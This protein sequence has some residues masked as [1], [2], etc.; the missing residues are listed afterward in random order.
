MSPAYPTFQLPRDI[1]RLLIF[2]MILLESASL[3]TLVWR[4][5]L[6]R[7]NL[8]TYVHNTTSTLYATFRYLEN[9]TL[10]DTRDC[11]L[12]FLDGKERIRC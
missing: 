2:V 9:I 10:S 12:A 6:N 8:V 11:Y 7:R 3:W 1:R 4:L 5:V